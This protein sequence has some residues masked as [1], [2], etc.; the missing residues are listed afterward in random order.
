VYETIL[1]GLAFAVLWRRRLS[2]HPDGY[3]LWMYLL[4]SGA[5]RFLV[6]VVR[7]N[8][9][10]A[11]GLSEAQYISLAIMAIGAVQIWRSSGTAAVER[12][13]PVGRAS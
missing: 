6:E 11:F 1:Y 10:I 3:I 12:A 5:A 4:L 7:I 2:P 9:K 13:A 8:P